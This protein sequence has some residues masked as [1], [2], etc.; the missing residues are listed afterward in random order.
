MSD[1][2]PEVVAHEASWREGRLFFDAVTLKEMVEQLAPYLSARVVIA[3]PSIEGFVGGGIVYVDN[4]E[5][6]F[7]AIERSWPVV[8]S[9]PSPDLIVLTRR[10]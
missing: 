9:R 1:L 3:D 10:R 7:A 4:A 8:V 5:S 6:V 2:A